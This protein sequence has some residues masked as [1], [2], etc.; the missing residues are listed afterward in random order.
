[1]FQFVLKYNFPSSLPPLSMFVIPLLSSIP[2]II[3]TQLNAFSITITLLSV[4][5]V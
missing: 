4:V 5:V 3:T 1:M 2:S